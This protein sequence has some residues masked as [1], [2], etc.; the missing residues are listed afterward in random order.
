[1]K[2]RSQDSL[3]NRECR[4]LLA[5]SFIGREQPHWS[6]SSGWLSLHQQQ[7]TL[8]SFNDNNIL[9]F[10][11]GLLVIKQTTAMI[12]GYMNSLSQV[13]DVRHSQAILYVTEIL[14]YN[15]WCARS[16]DLR[17][18]QIALRHVS[19]M[20]HTGLCWRPTVLRCRQAVITL[21]YDNCSAATLE[22]E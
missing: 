4:P 21:I 9:T 5:F 11:C 20:T 10:D 3:S 8:N 13:S 22:L 2:T 19:M 7:T 16:T 18:R 17:Y 14:G 1:M 12:V 6:R 15:T